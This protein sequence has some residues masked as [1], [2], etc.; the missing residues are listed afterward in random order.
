[1]TTRFNYRD[2]LPNFPLDMTNHKEIKIF[3]CIFKVFSFLQFRMDK[4]EM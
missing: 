1:M 3:A 4:H 2:D